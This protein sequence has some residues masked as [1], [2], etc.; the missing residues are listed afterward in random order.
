MQRT[1]FMS[2]NGG[3]GRIVALAE[4]FELA[5][6]VGRRFDLLAP[7]GRDNTRPNPFDAIPA[8]VEQADLFGAHEPFVSAGGIGIAAHLTEIDVEG[9]PGLG[10][11]DVH[12]N[13]PLVSG[14][15]QGFNGKANAAGVRDVRDGQDARLGRERASKPIDEFIR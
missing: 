10:T 4:R 14:L 2:G 6:A 12:M 8:N 1:L 9:T 13:V 3:Q 5:R 11:I 7:T 15:A